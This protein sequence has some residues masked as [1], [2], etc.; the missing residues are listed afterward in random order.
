MYPRSYRR[1]VATEVPES[2]AGGYREAAAVLELSPNA[3]AALSRRC[4]QNTIRE[5]AHIK[6]ANLS[7]EIKEL[8]SL[9]LVSS[10][11]AT[12]LDAIRQIGNFGAHPIKDTATGTVMDVEPGEA[13]WTLDL[14]DRLFDKFITQ[15]A[16]SAERKQALNAKLRAAGKEEIP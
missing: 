11:L 9:R 7:E 1:P 6:K 3:S 13:K 4:L 8:I 16:K 2:L 10:S 14:L 12:D 5:V 15:P